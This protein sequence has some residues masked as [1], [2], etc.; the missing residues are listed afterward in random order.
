M[1]QPQNEPNACALA[2]NKNGTQVS[3][4]LRIAFSEQFLKDFRAAVWSAP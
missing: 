1:Q 3:K 2:Q 4:R